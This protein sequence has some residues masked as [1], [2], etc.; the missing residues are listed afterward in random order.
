M[1]VLAPGRLLVAAWLFCGL[2]LIR[3]F[4]QTRLR[5]PRLDRLLRLVMYGLPLLLPLAYAGSGPACD[6]PPS[7]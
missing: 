4:L 7:A 5:T 3:S 6:T 1:D 2:G